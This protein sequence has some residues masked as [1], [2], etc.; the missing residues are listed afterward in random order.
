MG[1]DGIK[2]PF[3][4][5]CGVFKEKTES[6]PGIL[7]LGQGG[8]KPTD[9]R[10]KLLREANYFVITTSSGEIDNTSWAA[11]DICI[12]LLLHDMD[13]V[14]SISEAYPDKT[15]ERFDSVGMFL[16]RTVTQWLPFSLHVAGLSYN[17]AAPKEL[18]S[19]DVICNFSPIRLKRP[20]L[21]F[22]TIL[23]GDFSAYV[24]SQLL[25]G[26][27][28]LWN[29]IQEMFRE[30]NATL[31]YYYF[32]FDSYALP[33][34]NNKLFIDCRPIGSNSSLVANYLDRG[35]VFLHT[36]WTEGISNSIIEALT[37]NVP[38]VACSDQR[39]PIQ[40]LAAELP[41]AITLVE[42][43]PV[44][45][46]RAIRTI[47]DNY[48]DYAGVAHLF[49]SKFD[50]FE[51]NRRLV[52]GAQDWFRRNGYVW[53]GNCM[54]LF[55]GLQSKHDL[56]CEIDGRTCYTG[57]FPIY[58]DPDLVAGFIEFQSGIA[59]SLNNEPA[60]RALLSEAHYLAAAFRPERIV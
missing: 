6:S 20:Q 33:R 32:P 12:G 34:V 30:L 53:E 15:I 47:I 45:L 19:V 58:P 52:K 18:K 38:V 46:S 1:L 27:H 55:G 22:E 49:R 23:R 31:D 50:V 44:A 13:N 24:A 59:V 11:K 60:I 39:G 9:E 54:G 26:D 40:D 25:G 28:K 43:D 36:S 10:V 57:M 3:F 21:A 48:D 2:K 56:S 41:G 8:W 42:P 14:R 17:A 51:T 16:L 35:R 37:R 4:Q 7:I 29:E 5:S